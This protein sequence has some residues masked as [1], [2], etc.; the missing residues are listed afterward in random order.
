MVI[1]ILGP[2]ACYKSCTA[3]SIAK[4]FCGEVL[5]CDSVSVYKGLDIGSAKPSI[6]E[7]KMVRHHLIDVVLP[8]DTAFSASEFRN[9]A[10]AAIS[11]C[12]N[13]NRIP[14]LAGGSGMYFDAVMHPMMFC[15]PTDPVIR[16]QLEC[17]YDEDPSGFKYG[18]TM[19][20][21]AAGKR[22]ALNDKKR[23][24]RAMEVYQLSGRTFSS[25]GDD[26]EK[27]Q[28]TF[29]YRNIRIG[30]NLP[31]EILYKRIEGRVDKMMADGLLDEVAS[32][33]KEGLKRELPSMQSIGYA[34]LLDY[35]D[36]KCTIE[37]AVSEMKKAT[38]HLAK[39][40]LTWF[41]RDKGIR[42]FDCSDYDTTLESIK[43]FIMEKLHE[44]G[45]YRTTDF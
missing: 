25:F 13:R 2:T 24:V 22:I 33:R 12:T 26:Y 21:P 11:D 10:D 16:K 5:S 42:W 28:Q 38:R 14:V 45:T 18:L 34:Q 27:A 32:L 1:C 44:D 35:F 37:E 15:C 8:S 40:Q 3:I 29:R 4:E 31:R 30:L 6:Q 7:R 41:K 19:I 39:R 43:L 17:K 9:L 20:D 23:L 36:G